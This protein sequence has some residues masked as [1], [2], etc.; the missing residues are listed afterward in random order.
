M[1]ATLRMHNIDK[2]II[3]KI[4][5]VIQ[6]KRNIETK[7]ISTKEEALDNWNDVFPVLSI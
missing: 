2:I 7:H 5:L 6:K 1:N 4:P 3:K